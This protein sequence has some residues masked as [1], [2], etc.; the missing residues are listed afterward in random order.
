GC[1]V[2][3]PA[4]PARQQPG[5]GSE[6]EHPGASLICGDPTAAPR[7]DGDGAW[8]SSSIDDVLPPMTS[9]S[10]ATPV[11]V[12]VYTSRR[13]LNAVIIAALPPVSPNFRLASISPPLSQ[14]LCC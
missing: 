1:L 3:S 12:Q 13:S 7:M 9:A 2:G 5:R 11:C 14:L 10:S 8:F 4:I 6:P